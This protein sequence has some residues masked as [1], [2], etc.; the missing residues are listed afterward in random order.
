M[1]FRKEEAEIG[2]HTWVIPSIR[3]QPQSQANSPVPSPTFTEW[4]EEAQQKSK[5]GEL[6]HLTLFFF[7]CMRVAK[8][9]KG[10]KENVLLHLPLWRMGA[11]LW[12]QVGRIQ[13]V[14]K[15]HWTK[16]LHFWVIKEP[17]KTKNSWGDFLKTPDFWMCV[18]RL[19]IGRRRI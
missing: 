11:L 10:L 6:P 3:R 12:S 13:S 1:N 5:T 8:P 16:V 18:L 9:R 19:R 14:F 2:C 15:G 4:G 17:E 7:F